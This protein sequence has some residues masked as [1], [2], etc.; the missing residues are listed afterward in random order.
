MWKTYWS[1]NQKI[2]SCG[3][4]FGAPIALLL[5][6]V[7]KQLFS[8]FLL[9]NLKGFFSILLPPLELKRKEGFHLPFFF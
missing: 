5:K 7:I 9:K 6:R 8:G 1:K 2:P 4:F 3:Y